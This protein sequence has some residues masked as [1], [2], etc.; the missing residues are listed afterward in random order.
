MELIDKNQKYFTAENA[1]QFA[2]DINSKQMKDE[3]NWV[4][5]KIK[6]AVLEGKF[7]ITFNKV[8]LKST[9]DFLKEKEFKVTFFHGCQWDPAE[10]TTVS[11]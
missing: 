11:W 5:D 7:S 10:D 2:D 6:T 8:L 1:H 3:L 9:V 4:Y